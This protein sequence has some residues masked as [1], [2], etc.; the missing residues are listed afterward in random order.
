MKQCG[1]A[2]MKSGCGKGAI[3]TLKVDYWTNCHAPGLLAIVF[4]FNPE[5]GGILVCCE[6]GE[7]THNMSEGEYWVPYDKYKVSASRDA[8]LPIASELQK[9]AQYDIFRRI[10]SKKNKQ[11]SPFQNMLTKRWIQLAQ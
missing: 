2:S 5:T 11:E 4:D 9:S 10:Q 6:C 8:T 1:T 7:I 3:V